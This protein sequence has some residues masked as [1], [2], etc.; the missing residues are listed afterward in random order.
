M[1]CYSSILDFH[2][3][4]DATVIE[5]LRACKEPTFQLL[6]KVNMDEFGMGQVQ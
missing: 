6:G 3:P 2:A 1:D 5:R 4:F